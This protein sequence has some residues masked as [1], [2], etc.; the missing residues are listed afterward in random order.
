VRGAAFSRGF[1][2]E[3][4]GCP[5][6]ALDSEK[7]RLLSQTPKKKGLPW[8]FL[9]RVLWGQRS[10]HSDL[11]FSGSVGLYSCRSVGAGRDPLRPPDPE[12]ER[13]NYILLGI[14]C[15][16]PWTPKKKGPTPID[17]KKER[18][19]L[20]FRGVVDQQGKSTLDYGRTP[21]R[22]RRTAG[23]YGACGQQN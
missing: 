8:T 12:K 5:G 14:A 2:K 4:K 22:T 15:R 13:S 6:P 11:S 3:Q 17:P 21:E 16:T 1:A 7:E 23:E 18:S 19:D 20:S 9:F 10:K